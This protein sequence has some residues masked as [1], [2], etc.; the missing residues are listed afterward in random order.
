M[1]S[2]SFIVTL[3]T[4]DCRTESLHPLGLPVSIAVL[5]DMIKETLYKT[6]YTLF[7]SEVAA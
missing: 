4:A 3:N 2:V 1:Q 7:M 5:R 6:L